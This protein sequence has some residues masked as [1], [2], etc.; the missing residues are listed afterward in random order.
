[1][2]GAIV[3][4]VLAVVLLPLAAVR[5]VTLKELKS[6]GDWA[7]TPINGWNYA[8]VAI[9]FVIGLTVNVIGY[10]TALD[11]GN[12]NASSTVEKTIQSY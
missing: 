5:Y 11:N 8:V 12:H 10:R 4:L 6:H 9:G 7:K 2:L 1:M 3:S